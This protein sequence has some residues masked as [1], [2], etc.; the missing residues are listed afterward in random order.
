[1]KLAKTTIKIVI[2]KCYGGFSLSP[3]AMLR[4]SELNGNKCFFFKHDYDTDKYILI[5]KE[6]AKSEFIWHAFDDAAPD[7][8]TNEWYTQHQL[9]DRTIERH[10]PKLVQVVEELGEAANGTYAKLSIV[11]IPKDVPYEIEEYD[12]QEWIAEA[13]R[14]WS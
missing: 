3:E 4:Y 6:E 1:M 2:N 5:S 9:Y 7:I 13:H 14:K 11:E 8:M 10:D 12:G